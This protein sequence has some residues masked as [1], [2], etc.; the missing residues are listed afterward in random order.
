MKKF[1]FIVILTVLLLSASI[2]FSQEK[3]F[4]GF[5]EKVPIYEVNNKMVIAFERNSVEEIRTFLN[6]EK[7]E[8]PS[9]SIV[10]T[11][12]M[13]IKKIK[14]VC[15]LKKIIILSDC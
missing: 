1:N 10:I 5:D 13:Q 4:Y 7:I 2:L 11:N 3:Y 14:T 15:M 12:K 8:E 9:D 6:A